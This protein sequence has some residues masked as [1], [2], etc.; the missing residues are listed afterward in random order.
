MYLKRLKVRLQGV[1]KNSLTNFKEISR[2][3]PGYIFRESQKI[4]LCDKPYNSQN[5]GEVS[6]VMSQ[7]LPFLSFS[8]HLSGR[9][10][11]TKIK[12]IQFT[13]ELPCVQCTKNRL[14]CENYNDNY[15]SFQETELNSMRWPVFLGA[16]R[17]SRRFPVSGV[18][19]T[20]DFSTERQ[21]TEKN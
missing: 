8:W 10:V 4:F 12:V 18:V 6:H 16:F 19:D 15:K 3:Y 13:W 7:D 21:T 9:D 20:L 1:Y 14:L 17:N 2:R 11:N 5:T